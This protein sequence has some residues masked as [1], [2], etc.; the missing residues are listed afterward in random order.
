MLRCAGRIVLSLDLRDSLPRLTSA[1]AYLLITFNT[2]DIL[3]MKRSRRFGGTYLYV[4][5]IAMFA[6]ITM[7]R[8]VLQYTSRVS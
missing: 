4:S 8:R 2:V 3:L 5:A 6:A 7:V 1:G